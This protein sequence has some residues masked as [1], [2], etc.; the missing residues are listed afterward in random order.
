MYS[1]ILS[2]ICSLLILYKVSQYNKY[3]SLH[4]SW[5]ASEAIVLF[6]FSPEF[7]EWSLLCS[8]GPLTCQHH[9]FQSSSLCVRHEHFADLHW[10]TS[11]VSFCSNRR[12]FR[13]WKSSDLLSEFLGGQH[14]Q[15]SDLTHHS[16]H[17]RLGIET[18]FI[19]LKRDSD[20]TY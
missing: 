6:L 8:K 3:I 16:L 1:S 20:C 10:T 9:H 11:D 13:F 12:E 4:I 17:Q 18:A 5:R 2:I 19:T 15:S 14:S 7:W